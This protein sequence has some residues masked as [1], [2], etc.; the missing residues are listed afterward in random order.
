MKMLTLIC[1]ERIE[2]EVL[3]LFGDIKIKGYTVVADVGGSGQTGT[4]S[5]RGDWRDRNKLYLIAVDDERV[6]PIAHAVKEL[7]LRLVQ[8]HHGH[9]VP[10]KVFVQPCEMIL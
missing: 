5:G 9:E 10:L 2:D 7:H 4:V 1:G 3:V 6:A 8:E